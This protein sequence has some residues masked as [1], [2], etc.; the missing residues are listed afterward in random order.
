[1]AG[2]NEK[3]WSLFPKQN[4]RPTVSFEV[5]FGNESSDLGTTTKPD[6]VPQIPSRLISL[7]VFIF[8]F[9]DSCAAPPEKEK[10]FFITFQKTTGHSTEKEPFAILL[11]G[12]SLNR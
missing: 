12:Y 2:I 1:M 3:P 10:V 5:L 4:E 8:I 6:T 11:L 7:S 9:R